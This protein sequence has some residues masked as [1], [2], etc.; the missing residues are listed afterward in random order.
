M[1]FGV[2]A[3]DPR[4]FLRL[5]GESGTKFKEESGAGVGARQGSTALR[6]A[7]VRRPYDHAAQVPAVR[8]VREREG[9][10]D[11][12]HRQSARPSSCDAE[13][14]AY[15][16]NCAENRRDSADAVLGQGCCRARRGAMTGVKVQTV[17]VR[18]RRS[19]DHAGHVRWCATAQKT[20][21]FPQVQ[22]WTKFLTCPLW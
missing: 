12:V 21:E 16:A 17:Q 3:I 4:T 19:C 22:F 6:G 1:E 7:D 15:S 2:S 14:C 5:A 8:V 18:C 9:A 20:V 13:M 11:S 10:P